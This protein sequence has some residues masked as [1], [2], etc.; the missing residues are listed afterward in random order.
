MSLTKKALTLTLLSSIL[1]Q[2]S[3]GEETVKPE[4]FKPPKNDY[5][6]HIYPFAPYSTDK[7]LSRVRI[8]SE[9][10]SYIKNFNTIIEKRL[11]ARK[12]TTAL[13]KGQQAWMSTYWPL[14]KGLIANPYKPKAG[15][16]IVNEY[17]LWTPS[18]KKLKKRMQKVLTKWR[19]LDQEELDKMAPSE[20]YDILLGDESFTMTKK[21]VKY[22]YDWGS[23]K[24]NAFLTKID[25]VGENTINIANNYVTNR[26]LNG[27][28]QPF[29]DQLEALP[30]CIITKSI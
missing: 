24:E 29:A 6:K 14:N 15:I 8:L 27:D 1:C 22:M 23:K 12:T 30:L 13:N 2:T 19:E 3:F 18:Y 21:V 20:K 9:D 17:L 7:V 16:N 10:T 26:W 25:M 11:S 28:E 4:N 5:G